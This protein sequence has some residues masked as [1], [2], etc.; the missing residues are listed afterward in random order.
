MPVVVIEAK[1]MTALEKLQ[2]QEL[3]T[4]PR[5]AAAGN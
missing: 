5:H 1:R 3:D 4:S 2:S